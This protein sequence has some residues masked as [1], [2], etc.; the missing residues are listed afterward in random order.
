M[1]PE[2]YSYA[3]ATWRITLRRSDGRCHVVEYA[4]WL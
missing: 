4:S 1:S 2:L 3:G